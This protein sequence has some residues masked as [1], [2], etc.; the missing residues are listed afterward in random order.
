MDK[1]MKHSAQDV[2]IWL[3][4]E[5]AKLIGQPKE[6]LHVDEPIANYLTDSRD[7]LSLAADLQSWLHVEI[8][9]YV[10][11]DHP[12]IAALASYVVGKATT[13]P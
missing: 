12:T 10:V 5:I 4:A 1:P 2:E 9:A 8:S 7:A 13:P 3:V 11:W 6:Q